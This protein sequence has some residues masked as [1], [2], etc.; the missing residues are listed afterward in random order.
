LSL[1]HSA[2]FWYAG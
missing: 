2:E 1:E